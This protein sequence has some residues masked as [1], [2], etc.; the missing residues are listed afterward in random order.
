MEK[1]L[2]RVEIKKGKFALEGKVV[3]VDLLDLKIIAF[4]PSRSKGI[5]DYISAEYNKPK[6]ANAY[7]RGKPLLSYPS[8]TRMF[9]SL[10]DYHPV[11]YLK[12]NEKENKGRR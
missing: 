4:P 10:V 9:G 6:G 7:V 12:I 11:L 3:D 2:K 5:E 1:K 8:S